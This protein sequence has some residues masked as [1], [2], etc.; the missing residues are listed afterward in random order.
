MELE[1]SN[2]GTGTEENTERLCGRRNLAVVLAAGSGSRMHAAV[3][4]QFMCINGK[5]MFWYSL[6][7]F[8]RCALIDDILLVTAAE[9]CA[10]V[11]AQ[12]AADGGF[13]KIRAVIP[14]GKE[15]Y[16]SVANALLFLD[17][18]A[19]SCYESVLIHDSARPMLT[20]Q[21]ILDALDG[22]K[23][24]DAC[25]A[26]V[27]V[28]DTIKV[29]DADNYVEDTPDRSRLWAMQTPQAF[30]LPLVRGAYAALRR[31]EEAGTLRGGITDDAMVV[32]TYAGHPVKIIMGDYRNIKVTTP[33]DTAL[34]ELYLSEERSAGH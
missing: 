23:R 2:K 25:V 7:A 15:R 1:A 33:E 6:R 19:A 3:K 22:A 14:G 11:Q 5:P 27:P 18:S 21:L 16:D 13:S 24:Y 4:K 34:A 8:E 20:Q 26:G 17:D 9:D 28:K 29:L 30:S 31:E 12:L 32:E 10:Q